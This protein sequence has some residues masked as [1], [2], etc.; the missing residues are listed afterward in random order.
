MITDHSMW[1]SP[2]DDER[3]ARE[4]PDDVITG[5][6]DHHIVNGDPTS[7]GCLEH[8]HLSEEFM[9][10]LEEQ[11]M[12]F[13]FKNPLVSVG[14]ETTGLDP[15]RHEIWELALIRVQTDGTYAEIVYQIRPDLTAAD[16]EALEIN[17]FHERFR[18]P[19]GEHA[20]VVDTHSGRAHPIALDN[21]REIVTYALWR[22]V[23]IGS[24]TTF[25]ATFLRKLLDGNA[26][27]HYRVVNA[28]EL[29]AG[30]LMA[31]GVE[32]PIPWDSAEVSRLIGVEPPDKKSAHTALADARWASD[33]FN[34]VRDGVDGGLTWLST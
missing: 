28:L 5:W 19:D 15:D 24:N 29:A 14:T 30:A 7:C 9:K 31:R 34:A 2:G 10:Q 13:N 12:P 3:L 26:P 27:W 16:P 18:V 32:V 17:R 11:P 6:P 23:L 8:R 20:A 33:V 21:L 22:S 4:H 1:G 25:D